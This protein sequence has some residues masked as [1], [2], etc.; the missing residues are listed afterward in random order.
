MFISF[1]Y[2]TKDLKNNFYNI[3]DIILHVYVIIHH[4]III[5][6]FNIFKIIRDIH[7]LTILKCFSGGVTVYIY[8]NL[9]M[10]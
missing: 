1:Y 4:L 8:V 10:S 2:N 9:Y 3:F 7:E 6:K 5:K